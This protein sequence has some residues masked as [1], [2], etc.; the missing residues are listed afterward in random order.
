M[1]ASAGGALEVGGTVGATDFVEFLAAAKATPTMP[2]SVAKT[3]FPMIAL[4]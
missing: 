3:W 2:A 1:G 4:S